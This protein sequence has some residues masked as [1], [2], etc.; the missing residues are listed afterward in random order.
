MDLEKPSGSRVTVGRLGFGTWGIGGITPGSTSYAFDDDDEAS[1]ALS[2]ASQSGINF[3]D[4][5]NL[6]GL[7]H[8]EELLG[9]VLGSVRDDVI[10][11]TKGGFTDFLGAP[12]F[13]IENIS[14]SLRGSLSRLKTDY[15][16]IYQ[17][18][19]PTILDLE[20]NAET[21]S[22]LADLKRKK[23]ISMIGV[24]VKSPDL[25]IEMLDR[26]PFDFVQANFNMLDLRILNHGLIKE[27][28]SRSRFIARTP[29]A[30]GFLSGHIDEHTEFEKTDHR[31]SWPIDQRHSWVSGA[32]KIKG[33]CELYGVKEPLYEVAIRFC[34]SFPEVAV[35]IPGMLSCQEVVANLKALKCGALPSDLVEGIIELNSQTIFLK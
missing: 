16:D 22:F 21:L 17:L 2:L 3:F 13:S 1:L 32:R 23:V 19:N 14:N 30:F 8:S 7:G 35:V 12:N 33:L 28:S 18:H 6:Y 5:S 34:L 20:D 10:F 9:S 24:S 31:S 15:L 4:T 11:A 29:L 26:F 25:A 27:V